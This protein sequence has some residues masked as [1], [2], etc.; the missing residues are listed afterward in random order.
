MSKSTSAELHPGG[1]S[2]PATTRRD[3]GASKK[4]RPIPRRRAS[5]LRGE[6]PGDTA[7]S[8][9]TMYDRQ[10]LE[11]FTNTTVTTPRATA[12][13]PHR[14]R[15]RRK[16]KSFFKRWRSLSVRHTWLM[17]LLVCFLVVALYAIYPHPSNPISAALFLSYPLPRAKGDSP[18]VLIHYGKGKKDFAFV[19]F[20]TIFLSFTREFIMQRLLRPLSIKAGLKSRAKQARFMEQAYT[21]VYFAVLGPLG[22]YVMSRT[23]VWYFSTAG[24]L[25]GFPH[26]THDAVFKT[27]YLMQAAYWAQQ[28][29]VLLMGLEKPRKDFKELVAH[30]IITLALIFASYRFHFT[31]MG[32]AVYVTMDVSD[33]FLATSK[34]LNYIEAPIVIP[35]F[36]IFLSAWAYLRHFI[37]LRILSSMIPLPLPFPDAV[38]AQIHTTLGFAGNLTST[39][40]GLASPVLNPIASVSASLF[41][42]TAN[43][44][45]K[46]P[47][48]VVEWFNTPPTF[49]TIGPYDLNWET[50]QYKCW[51]SQWIVFSMLLALQLVNLFWFFLI[52]RILWRLVASWGE[53]VEDDRSDA[54]DS[55][56]G[57]EDR[58]DELDTM[59]KEQGA[60]GE[61]EKPAL[62]VNGIPLPE[63][64][65]GVDVMVANGEKR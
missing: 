4:E 17:P 64:E 63:G 31:Y 61:L 45:S 26:K 20:Y 5:S 16:V 35:Y 62:L 30:H 3:T 37:N 13:K 6:P 32:L 65:S 19:A 53:V 52:L 56:E 38:N 11:G 7:P 25:E 42:A 54:D 14:G 48:M 9:S 27:Y 28:M 1:H 24:M 29:I 21:A 47:S 36:M 22:L 15:K 60:I 8:M 58:K 46:A 50:Q 44:I 34:L 55:V 51:I 2:D 41:P 43:L 49:Q 10:Q 59:R 23:P 40:F 57:T 12:E 33:F 18:D 39:G